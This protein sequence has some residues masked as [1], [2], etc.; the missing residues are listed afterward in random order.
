[1]A[2]YK[3]P[4][5]VEADDKLLGPFSFR[6]C[7]YILIAGILLA[8][9][10]GLFQIFPALAIIP[11]PFALFLLILA[12]P[13]K[14]DQPMETYVAALISYWIKP[15]TRL[16]TPGQ[17]ESTIEI[18]AP[19]IVEAPRTRNLT[20]DEATH[21]LSFLS[22]IVD[23]GG[24]SING[25][26]A[27]NRD[28]AA[29]AANTPDIFESGRF[30][31]L[32]GTI[33]KDEDARRAAVVKEMQAAIEK[34]EYIGSAPTPSAPAKPAVPSV[35]PAVIQPDSATSSHRDLYDFVSNLE[36]Q[37]RASGPSAPEQ[38]SSAPQR[39]LEP[40]RTPESA[41][42]SQ[43]EEQKIQEKSRAETHSEKTATEKSSKNPSPNS[44]NQDI[45][46]LTTDSDL[47]IATIQ[48]EAGRINKKHNRDP[49]EVF[50]SLH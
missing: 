24:R 7:V 4:Q 33:R 2:R 42:K 50:I 21:R 27:V 28:F 39:P 16:W 32:S 31:S 9:A 19:K 41:E 3:V 38:Q 30:N 20:S 44:P 22:D 14:K 34:N 13:L 25:D 35:S 11:V 43:V 18:S 8:C 46:E 37:N 36:A 6:Q 23:S 17:R 10:V 47:S 48:K 40:Q 49:G 15:R 12:L 1:M 5:D 26:T 29:E 45:I